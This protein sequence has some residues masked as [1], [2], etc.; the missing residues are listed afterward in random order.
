M[1]PF[2][3]KIIPSNFVF[4]FIAHVG[5]SLE[6]GYGFIASFIADIDAGYDYT[7]NLT[8]THTSVR[9]HIFTAS[10]LQLLKLPSGL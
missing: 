10:S 1:L 8:I 2:P 6:T 7:I 9:N 4:F 5:V 3:P